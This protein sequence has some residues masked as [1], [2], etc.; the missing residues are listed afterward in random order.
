MQFSIV[1]PSVRGFRIVSIRTMTSPRASRAVEVTLQMTLT[2][3]TKRINAMRVFTIGNAH[4]LRSTVR[5]SAP[6]LFLES[7]VSRRLH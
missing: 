6:P 1:T 5:R 7:F 4:R 3:V 2:I